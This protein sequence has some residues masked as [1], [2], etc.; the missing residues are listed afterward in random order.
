MSHYTALGSY[1]AR[2]KVNQKFI[3]DTSGFSAEKVSN[4][5]TEE[6]TLVYAE[7]FY[8]IIKCTSLDFDRSCEEVFKGIDITTFENKWK[9]KLGE[10][11]FEYIRPQ[12]Y[13][14]E[15]TGI[16][17]VRLNKLLK[18]INKRPYAVEVYL[19]SKVL[20]IKSSQLFN[21][22]YGDGEKPIV[23]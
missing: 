13:L 20:K 23:G 19:I 9:S 17:S 3:A 5:Y 14:S 7:E 4:Y 12:N 18:E 2:N 6:S 10:F 1:L 22:L 11:L 15:T 21:Y 8:K 16:D